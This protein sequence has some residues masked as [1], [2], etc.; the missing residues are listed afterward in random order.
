MRV[1]L[2]GGGGREH[3][4]AEAVA[5]AGGEIHSFLK[6]RNPGILRKS[7][8][9]RLG[10]ET[11]VD[12]VAA[13]AQECRAEMI[14]IGPEAPLAAGL[15]DRLETEGLLVVGPTRQA[16]RIETSK[17]FARR[18]LDAHRVPG[19]IGWALCSTKEEARDA[20]RRFGGHVAVKPIGLT[21]G[22][23]VKVSGDHLPDEES[24]V[25]YAAEVIST[26]TGG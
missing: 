26:G 6:N 5:R 22:K 11:D 9:H 14:V 21:G 17:S 4:I 12:R 19:R 7:K 2:V 8:S 3:A 16:A 18:L 13:F 20:V 10:P 1:L 15:A 25:D 23:G 24:A